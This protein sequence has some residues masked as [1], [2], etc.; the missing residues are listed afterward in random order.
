L[1]NRI[2]RWSLALTNSLETESKLTII[3]TELSKVSL[4]TVQVSELRKLGDE[5]SGKS[6]F[7]GA[8]M[9][10]SE[11]GPSVISLS[12]GD[13]EDQWG[14]TFRNVVGV[15]GLTGLT[16]YIEPKISLDHFAFIASAGF[17]DGRV[18]R[19]ATTSFNRSNFV[20][21]WFASFVAHCEEAF[22][23]GEHRDYQN[24]SDDL[25]HARGRIAVKPTYANIAKGKASI[26]CEFSAFGV[27]NSVNRLTKS[28]LEAISR[29]IYTDQQVKAKARAISNRI[30]AGPLEASD[31]REL[32]RDI[33]QR[34]H[35]V[36]SLAKAILQ[37]QVGGNG[38]GVN[39]KAIS[40]LLPTPLLIES[41]IR[42]LIAAH[43]PTK[44]KLKSTAGKKI[45]LPS[46][47]SVN[48]DLVFFDADRKVAATGDVK[49]KVVASSIQRTD[50][51]QATTFATAFGVKVGLVIPF[52]TSGSLSL[53]E[54]R[55]GEVTVLC[56]PWIIEPGVSP[57]DSVKNL[58]DAIS[59]AIFRFE[60]RESAQQN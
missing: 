54:A 25:T 46:R 28:A 48:P 45:L 43:L 50:L 38:S 29:H 20:N 37:S 32:G 21:F 10:E 60:G 23:F 2:S 22:R 1:T 27:D 33:P 34:F 14:L 9:R 18:S 57:Q 4:T 49:Y 3:E 24:L 7:W 36:L 39:R 53:A 8:H 5:L 35:L 42:A 51:Y 56:T 30:F 12:R 17:A 47:L 41:G 40:F 19:S 6:S 16:I 58:V 31:F 55:V 26:F 59:N 44:L 11:E 52:A 13:S 15:V